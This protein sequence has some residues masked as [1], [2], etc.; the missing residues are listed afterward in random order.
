MMLSLIATL[1][2]AVSQAA[3]SMDLAR[4][5]L[6]GAKRFSPEQVTQLSGLTLGKPVTVNELNAAAQR[7]ANSGFFEEVKYRYTLAGRRATVVYELREIPWTIPVTFDNFVWFKKEEIVAALQPEL[8][9]FDSTLPKSHEMPDRMIRALQTLLESRKIPGRVDFAPEMKLGS[10]EILQYVFAVKDPSPKL[11]AVR[12][13]GASAIPEKDLVDA[14]R[15]AS[16]ADYSGFSIGNLVKGTLTNMYRRRGHW[17][18]S[19][20]PPAASLTTDPACAGVA[21]ELAV[22]EGTPYGFGGV[23]WSGNAALPSGKLDAA[24]GLSMGDIADIDKV[25]AGLR[26]AR[27]Q[28][29]RIGH[30]AMRSTYTPRVD[31][32]ARRVV[33]DVQVAEGP[34]FRMGTLEVIG[35]DAAD[36]D[37]I[38]KK[39]RLQQGE[40]YDEEYALVFQMKEM[41]SFVLGKRGS[42]PPRVNTQVDPSGRVVN[43]RIVAQ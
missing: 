16:G 14:L 15:A 34:Q 24:F 31:D 36:A 9:T 41:A 8:P 30:L 38:T 39:W 6:V 27:R 11:C 22:T 26:A 35:I 21:L 33:F 7:L 32:A 5:E 12:I 19:F 18:V 40:P 37:A 3:P 43:V 28:Y 1:V 23:Q 2:F 42:K 20:A 13:T 25:D 4:V 17:R 29:G 10:S